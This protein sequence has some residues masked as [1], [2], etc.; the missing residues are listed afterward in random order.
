MTAGVSLAGMVTDENDKP[1]ADAEVGWLGWNWKDA[2]HAAMAV[3]TTR[4]DGRFRFPHV[5]EEPLRIQ[6]K[7]KGHAP[8][9]KELNELDR[10][11]HLTVKLGR[12]R[13]LL[14][15]VVDTA[16]EPIPDAFLTVDAMAQFSCAW[17][18]SQD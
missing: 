5:P 3:T 14:G 11:G 12:P 16:G 15:R 1:I 10:A 2:F 6:V 17:R 7:A 18:L 4:A 13:A 8:E 9:F